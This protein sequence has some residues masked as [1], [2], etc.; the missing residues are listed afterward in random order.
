MG[1]TNS[2]EKEITHGLRIIKIFANSPASKTDLCIYTDFIVD[3][4]D[5]PEEFS[6]DRDFYKFIITNEN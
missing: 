1:G 3:I 6:L 5:C 4:A 2:T